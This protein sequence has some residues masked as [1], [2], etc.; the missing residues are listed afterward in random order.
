MEHVRQY[1]NGENVLFKGAI[2]QVAKYATFMRYD[3]YS[4]KAYH[5]DR[6][7]SSYNI[8]QQGDLAVLIFG[9]NNVE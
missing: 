7:F 5:P 1:Q 2:L 3:P 4:L 9:G 8:E 6:S